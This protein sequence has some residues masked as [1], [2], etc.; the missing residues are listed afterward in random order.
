MAEMRNI[1]VLEGTRGEDGQGGRQ[2][3]ASQTS[4]IAKGE[5]MQDVEKNGK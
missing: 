5:Y 2:T 4:T 1:S 3:S